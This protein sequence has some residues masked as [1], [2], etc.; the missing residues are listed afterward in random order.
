MT[1]MPEVHDAL[2][3]A[4]V[5]RGARRRTWRPS[6]R[7]GLLAVGAVIATGSAVAAT[8]GWHPVLGDDHRGHPR[9]ARAPIPADETAALGVLRRAQTDADRTPQVRAVLRMLGRGEINGVHTDGIRVLR[10]RSDGVTV[11]VPI[12]RVGRHDKGYP[13]SIRRDV[14]CV[15]TGTRVSSRTATVTDRQGHRKTL[16]TPGG[17]MT[18]A[19]CGGLDELRTTGIGGATNTDRGWVSSKL[20]PDG[21]ASVVIRLRRHRTIAV[22]VHDNFYELNTGRELTPAWGVRWLDASGNR[23]D[24]RRDK[25]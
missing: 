15:M 23:I 5:A 20:V 11:L 2:A 17:L 18:G 14:L 1:L 3:R 24:H 9:E 13:S 16:R 21:V 10:T 12:E 8:G 4:V 22:A 7:V 6:R 25:H 19:S